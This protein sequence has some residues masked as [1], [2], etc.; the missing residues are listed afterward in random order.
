MKNKSLGLSGISETLL[1]PLMG[2]A[3]ETKRR[4]GILKDLK[5]LEIYESLD[6]DF[7]KF[8]E[9]HSRRSMIRTT[10]RTAIVD[11]IVQ[12]HLQDY[13]AGTVVEI[14][15]GLNSR[16]ERLNPTNIQWFDLDVPQVYDIWQEH[17]AE[18]DRRRF[19]PYSAFDEEWIEKV[20]K[21]A[22][23]P[24]LFISEA[25]VIYF[26]K[27]KVRRLFQLLTEHFPGSYYLFDTAQ[28]AFI[29]SLKQNEDA[30]K[31]CNARIQWAIENI[32]QLAEWVPTIEVLQSIDLESPNHEYGAIYPED[33]QQAAEG[34]R[35]NLVKF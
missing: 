2:R 10:I 27:Q 30:L 20:K 19:L 28:P 1:I 17:F 33:F 4:N 24:F 25:S 9:V 3:L 29:T 15:C 12:S 32:N 8:D 34:Y 21:T 13:P 5:S 35:L 6:Y 31:F 18:T 16:F 23:S 26:S 7:N 11:R 22:R 14:G